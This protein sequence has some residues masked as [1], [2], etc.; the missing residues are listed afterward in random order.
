[1]NNGVP[2]NQ[3]WVSITPTTSWPQQ[4]LTPSGATVSPTRNNTG[5]NV[6]LPTTPVSTV[7]A[8]QRW[9][10]TPGKMNLNLITE[11]EVYRALMDSVSTAYYD[12]I[13]DHMTNLT[14]YASGGNYSFS[15]WPTG[16]GPY[17]SLWPSNY[18]MM[19]TTSTPAVG[20]LFSPLGRLRWE[21]LG[22]QVLLPLC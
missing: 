7:Y 3:Q 11:E 8:T 5:A 9:Q 13:T 19:T 12:L 4:M 14:N 20:T 1:M 22:A 16:Q 21:T 15:N 18:W 10:R 2:A 17:G 6:I